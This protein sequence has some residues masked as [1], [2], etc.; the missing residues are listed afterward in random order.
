MKK[1]ITCGKALNPYEEFTSSGGFFVL[2]K[3]SITAE[4]ENSDT[5]QYRNNK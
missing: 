4:I 2:R 1:C 5:T 3:P